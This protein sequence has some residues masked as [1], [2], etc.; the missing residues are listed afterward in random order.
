MNPLTHGEAKRL[1]IHAPGVH[2][3]GGQVLLSALLRATHFAPSLGTFDS[4][5]NVS[6]PTAIHF[7]KV[8]PSLASRF[9]TEVWL[10][11]NVRAGDVVLCL[12]GLPPLFRLP[13]HVCAFVQ[14]RHQLDQRHLASFS[15]RTRF[16][17]TIERV[18][19][20]LCRA[21]VDDYIV[22]TPS[23]ARALAAW[24]G[25]NPPVRVMPFWEQPPAMRD[26]ADQPPIDFVYVADGEA[27]KNHINL[28]AAWGL[29][30]ESGLRPSLALTLGS[31]DAA[32]WQQLQP[33]VAAKQLRVENLGHLPHAA[34][35]DLYGRSRA[36]IFPS[37]SESFGLPLLE[38]AAA[39]LP[40]LAAERDFVRDACTP[41]QTFDP[42]SPTSIARAVRRFLAAPEPGLQLRTPEQFVR[43]LLA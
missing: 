12:H 38:A 3:G 2:T 14:N 29:L 21:N 42:E 20:L 40:I 8:F 37:T 43:E 36:L 13:A 39:G 27:H 16:R 30:A 35:L 15:F 7:R 4:R 9:A 19:G 41:V 25:A 11:R 6:P 26:T 24:H 34:A 28:I 5:A 17:L 33:A 23:M 22:Q 31:R 32:L 10:Y 18:I 1:V